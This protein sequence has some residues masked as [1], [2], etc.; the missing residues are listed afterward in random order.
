MSYESSVRFRRPRLNANRFTVPGIASLFAAVAGRVYWAID[1]LGRRVSCI[2]ISNNGGTSLF[3]ASENCGESKTPSEVTFLP[4]L[5]A[6]V[7]RDVPVHF[8]ST[9]RTGFVMLPNSSNSCGRQDRLRANMKSTDYLGLIDFVLQ[10]AAVAVRTRFGV[11][12][13]YTQFLTAPA[14]AGDLRRGFAPVRAFTCAPRSS[15]SSRFQERTR[16]PVL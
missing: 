3:D 14:R 1:F 4:M 12:Q 16:R 15:H 2:R 7:F 6:L 11:E 9:E 5:L 8:L 10:R 13:A